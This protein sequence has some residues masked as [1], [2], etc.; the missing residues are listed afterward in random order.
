MV[1]CS[2]NIKNFMKKIEEST[3]KEYEIAQKARKLGYD[4]EDTVNIPLATDIAERCVGLVSAVVPEIKGQNIEERMRNLEKQYGFGDW[5]VAFFIASETAQ[6]KFYKFDSKQK[7]LET[8]VRLGLAYITSGVTCAPLEGFIELKLKKRK[9]GEEYCSVYYAGPIRSAGGTASAVSVLIADFARKAIGIKDYDPTPKEAKRY[10]R[11]LTDYNDRVSRLQY[12]AIEEEIDFLVNHIPVELNGDPTSKLE[13][14]NFKRLE[15]VETDLIRGGM[16][17]V[18]GE[19][20]CLKA[21]KIIKK[22]KKWGSEV[23]MDNWM[24]LAEYVEMQKKIHAKVGNSND[25]EE[26]KNIVKAN[27]KFIEELVAGRPVFTHPLAVG[28]F[29]LRYGRSRFGGLAAACM[30]PTSMRVCN[31]F[32]ATG[33]QLKVERPG[34]A[35]AI[36]P[37]DSIKGPLIKLK[38]GDVIWIK[39]E[40]EMKKYYNQVKEVIFLGDILFNYGDF[41]ENGS[42]LVPPGYVEEWWREELKQALKNNIVSKM[43]L[44]NKTN[45]NIDLV[46]K[47]PI[48]NKI[49]LSDAKII[50][51]MANIPLHPN[52]LFFWKNI[53]TEDLKVLINEFK[54]LDLNNF[55][56]IFPISLK[57]IFEN[58]WLAHNV[59]DNKL[60]ITKTNYQA[61][62]INLGLNNN[63]KEIKGSNSLEIINNLSNYKIKDIGGTFI[64]N[65]MGRP[66]KQR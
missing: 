13:V 53:K 32:I 10:Y 29:R 8:G 52:Y 37:C 30:N 41:V 38:N 63:L 19:G 9:D 24:F 35:C 65:R 47:D 45:C 23:G 11:E 1:V 46:L 55:D 4:P 15:R 40:E 56:Y 6:N 39:D 21:K 57:N 59:I 3:L 22:I 62:I 61:L 49:S 18:L 27:N 14:S 50:S 7:A 42:S 58:L 34:K 17:L 36:S 51:D 28:G 64:G 16:C 25:K 44:Q 26:D 2:E 20:M 66:E 43:D 31:N 12:H 5:R 54:K 60:Q 33:V 48:L